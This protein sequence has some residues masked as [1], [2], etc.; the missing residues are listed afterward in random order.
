MKRKKSLWSLGTEE[1]GASA[2]EY[3]ILLGSIALAVYSGVHL[4]GGKTANH[5][6]RAVQMFAAPAPAAAPAP[7]APPAAPETP[8][9]GA[10]KPDSRPAGGGQPDHGSVHGGKSPAN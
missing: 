5:Y 1:K 9:P 3:V 6:S 10:T 7:E 4:L 8:D 2:V